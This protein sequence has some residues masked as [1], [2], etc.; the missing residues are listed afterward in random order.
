MR[1]IKTSL[2]GVVL[3]EPKVYRDERGFFLESYVKRKYLE[4]G[5]GGEFVQDNHSASTRNVLRGL[6]FQANRGQAKLVRV[7]RGEIF[8]VAVDVRRGSPSFGQWTGHRLSAE[9]MLQMYLPVG[10]A[11]GFCV[12]S[13]YA[14]VVYKCTDYYS[15][16]DE[17][18]IIWNDPDIG[19]EW[20]VDSPI[21]SEKDR[22]NPRLREIGAFSPVP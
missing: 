10:F 16:G 15:P 19:I 1:A 6:H 9:N 18:G 20:P 4:L 12:L 3:V 2:D 21:L 13:D 8:D 5:I 17:R 7:L 14:E 22:K 11:H